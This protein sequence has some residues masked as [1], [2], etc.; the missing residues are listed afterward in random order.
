MELTKDFKKQEFDSKDGASMPDDVLKNIK[1]LA[2]NLQILRDF[3]KRKITI[4]SGY[5]SPSYNKKIGGVSNSFHLSG[6]AADI[7]VDGLEP[8][9]VKQALDYLIAQGRIKQ[10]GIGLYDEFIHY[11]IRGRKAFWDYRKTAQIKKK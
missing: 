1:E 2:Q 5:R 9:K 7:K 11:D 6:K 10:G 4:N 8:L 3:L